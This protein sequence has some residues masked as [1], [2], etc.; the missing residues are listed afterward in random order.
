[1]K[2]APVAPDAK[3]ASQ[4]DARQHPH[5]HRADPAGAKR[6]LTNREGGQL[7]QF[8]REDDAFG[9]V[10]YG[11]RTGGYP[12]GVRVLEQAVVDTNLLDPDLVM[13]VGDLIQ[14]YS[15][16]KPWLK[17]M[18]EFRGVMDKLA[19]PWFPVAG[20]HDVYWRGPKRPV[21]EHD[22]N[23]EM[24][25]GPLWYAFEHKKC[26]FFVLYSDEGD[27]K[28]GEKTFNKSSAQTMSPEQ[29]SWLEATLKQAKEARHVFV[30][31][32]HPRWLGGRRY[33]DDWDR[34]HK[35]LATSGKVRAVFAGHIHQMRYDGVRDGIAYYALATTGGNLRAELPEAGFLHHFHA[36]SVRPEG[37]EVASLPVGVV[38]DPEAFTT[39]F[40]NDV[41]KLVKRT[42][43]HVEEPLRLAA[44]SSIDL[45]IALVVKNPA[46][47]PLDVLVETPSIAGFTFRPDHQHCEIAPGARKTLRFHLHRGG[48]TKKLGRFDLPQSLRMRTDYLAADRRIHLPGQKAAL[49][50]RVPVGKLATSSVPNGF[51]GVLVLDGDGDAVRVP[52][53]L[54]QVPNGPFTVETWLRAEDV[55]A[56]R[57]GIACKC[58]SSEFGLTMHQGAFWFGSLQGEKYSEVRMISRAKPHRIEAGVW[59]HVAGVWDGKESRVYLDGKL[60][61]RASGSGSRRTN[62]IP[63]FIGA[64]PA[65]S[66]PDHW[67]D[68]MVDDCR[69][70]SEARYSGDSFTPDPRGTLTPD[71]AT[72]ALYTFETVWGGWTLDSGPDGRHGMLLG[73]ARRKVVRTG[74]IR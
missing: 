11:D 1:M 38:S 32:H 66:G 41:E 6:L 51:E 14:G 29:F 33:G 65:H 54:F 67:F 53:A 4:R 30:F 39:N 8:P 49:D 28:T 31:L 70:S 20:N 40:A 64:D 43:A 34:V 60:L 55:A 74:A 48:S 37:I 71:A 2:P 36:V 12:A 7:L 27:P 73:D 42:I 69:V 44:D 35:L 61:G 15:T 50:W 52:S 19:M 59:H 56:A 16:D 22:R 47:R 57:Q 25:F 72:F 21:G 17:Q 9:F 62:E 18:R 3:G 13:T 46:S 24:Y 68:G 26:F 63:F 23:Y 58:E 5:R 45:E 10:V